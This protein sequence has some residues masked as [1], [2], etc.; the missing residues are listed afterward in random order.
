MTFPCSAFQ[1]GT[2]VPGTLGLLH[3][4]LPVNQTD[5]E[6]GAYEYQRTMQIH[7][8][9]TA[10]FKK[11]YYRDEYPFN[12]GSSIHIRN[13]KY[14]ISPCTFP[15]SSLYELNLLYSTDNTS[16]KQEAHCEVL[17][18]KVPSYHTQKKQTNAL[19]KINDGL[20]AMFTYL[21]IILLSDQ[22]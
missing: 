7:K 4:L 3:F 21:G 15:P 9:K 13:Q 10:I 8:Y 14:L 17:V 6:S 5:V 22:I 12:E 1:L 20:L 16:E 18:G 11:V 2:S 19:M